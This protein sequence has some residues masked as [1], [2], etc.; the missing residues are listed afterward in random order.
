M[1]TIHHIFNKQP[2]ASEPRMAL[3][4]VLTACLLEEQVLD[5]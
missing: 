2:Y 4:L 1:D 3:L 5:L